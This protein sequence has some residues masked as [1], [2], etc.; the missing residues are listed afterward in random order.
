MTNRTDDLIRT[1]AEAPP[2]RWRVSIFLPTQRTGPQTRQ[3]PIRFGN[4]VD[5]AER[6][7]REHDEG[8]RREFEQM[9]EPARALVEDDSFWNDQKGGLAVFLDRDE[10]RTIRVPDELSERCVVNERF[11][12]KPL[13]PRLT[14]DRSYH[15]LALSRNHVRLFECTRDTVEQ[16]EQGDI[17]ASI[18]DALGHEVEKDSL[19]AHVQH[20]QGGPGQI[21]FHGHGKG[22]DDRANELLS[23]LQKVDA[24]VHDRI[25]GRDTPLVLAGVDEV[26]A[27]F[28]ENSRLGDRIVDESVSGNPDELDDRRLHDLS[29]P[30]VEASL[31]EDLDR[32]REEYARLAGTGRTLDDVQAVLEATNAGRVRTLLVA[33]D[34][35]RWGRMDEDENAI[36]IHDEQRPG[37]EDLVDRAANLGQRRGADVIFSVTQDMPNQAPLAAILHD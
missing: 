25:A 10:M 33:I 12:L 9:L 2:E 32:A 4:L 13:L 16:L 15:L 19:Q 37:D 30:L 26:T 8:L 6:Q 27:V 7:I 24:G 1:L 5:E 34:D 18:E 36:E 22:D 29:W 31:G 23:F 20:R 28:R 11:H 17:P 3:N 21:R 14:G 35:E